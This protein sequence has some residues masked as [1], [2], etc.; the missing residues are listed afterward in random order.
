MT[1]IETL[2][3]LKQCYMNAKRD[4]E[5]EILPRYLDAVISSFRLIS[6][7][8]TW[9]ETISRLD[10]WNP[11]KEK[12]IAKNLAAIAMEKQENE[13]PKEKEN[14]FRYVRA[15]T[16]PEEQAKT[17]KERLQGYKIP[18]KQSGSQE[19]H[20]KAKPQPHKQ[21]N[22]RKR[23]NNK[24]PK[25]HKQGQANQA[26]KRK[27]SHQQEEKEVDKEKW[28]AVRDM[29]KIFDGIKNALED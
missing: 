11:Y 2:I 21:N 22:K 7:F 1:A 20:R 17:M 28:L 10:G 16:P 19:L 26:K 3:G 25:Q 5:Y 24:P 6:S 14:Q 12:N 27:T 23:R 29:A 15:K 9:K 8:L 18:K 4:E 13:P